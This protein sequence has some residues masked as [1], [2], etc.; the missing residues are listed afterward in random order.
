MGTT[1]LGGG[2][3]KN[4]VLS[5]TIKLDSTNEG[6]E[7]K[8]SSK[9]LGERRPPRKMTPY[10]CHREIKGEQLTSQNMAYRKEH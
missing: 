1:G 8:K 6:E 9:K 3:E 2:E 5:E 4:R 10:S 7:K